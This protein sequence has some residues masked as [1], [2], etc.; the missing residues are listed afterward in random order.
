MLLRPLFSRPLLP[1][2]LLPPALLPLVL[3]P[4][5]VVASAAL[6]PGPAH[7]QSDAQ[8]A[9]PSDDASQAP[10]QIRDKLVEQGFKDVKVVPNSYLVGARNKNGN[11]V[12]MMIGPNSMTMLTAP[13]GGGDSTAE[14]PGDKDKPVQQ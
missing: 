7:A 8:P 13:N 2:A 11:P 4:L 6:V 1:P 10:R 12:M 14:S 9:G 3:A 5:V